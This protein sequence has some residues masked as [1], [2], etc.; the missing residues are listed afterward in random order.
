MARDISRYEGLFINHYLFFDGN[1]CM[2]WK[3]ETMVFLKSE[4]MEVQQI[5]V[6]GPYIQGQ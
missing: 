5:V 4:S 1:D 3:T 6:K 2:Y